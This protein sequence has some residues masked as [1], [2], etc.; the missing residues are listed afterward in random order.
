MRPRKNG[1]YVL[2]LDADQ[3]PYQIWHGD[4]WECP[5]CKHRSIF[6]WGQNPIAEHYEDSFKGWLNEVTF[7]IEGK[8]RS[9]SP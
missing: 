5:A 1:V 2:V 9:L 7:T 4:L 3:R 8:L 6:G